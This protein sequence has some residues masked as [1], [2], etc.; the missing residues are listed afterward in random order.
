[1]KHKC[2]ETIVYVCELGHHSITT[3]IDEH[4]KNERIINV[5][6]MPNEYFSVCKYY[7]Y[8]EELEPVN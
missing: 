6:P 5:V 4:F 8:S 1:M 7:I 2:K 3:Y